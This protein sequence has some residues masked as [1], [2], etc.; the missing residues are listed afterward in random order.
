M[1]EPRVLLCAESL[2]AGRGGIARVARLTARVLAAEARSRGFAAEA[3]ALSDDAPVEDLGLPVRTARGSRLRFV[4]GVHRSALA[5]THLVYDFLGMARAHP[6]LPFLRLPSW[7]WINGIEVW[8]GAA[9]SRIA[10]GRRT[11][12]L[13]SISEHTR[14]RA[15]RFDEGFGRARICWLGTESD[16][17]PAPAPAA[18]RPPRAILVGRMEPGRDKGHEAVLSVWPRVVE[19]VPEA[20]LTIVGTGR[21]E[22]ELRRQAA[23]LPCARSVEFLGFVPEERMTAVLASADV[24][25]MPSRT[26]GFGLVYIEAM[27]HGVAVIASVH[28]AGA[29]VNLDG[30]TGFNVDLGR[31]AELLD[32]LVLLLRDRRKA[33]L[34]GENGRRRWAEH[35]RFGAFRARCA[36]LLDEFLRGGGGKGAP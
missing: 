6:R 23:G 30:V 36:A 3:L 17:P 32:R 1:A 7:S 2:R 26:E 10:A 31:S 27:R 35:F 14:A 33:R 22:G 4:C 18:D 24:L 5:C 12:F 29:E 9:R 25:A 15:S 20:V 21:A 34:L 19:A 8:E 13:V 28:D 11:S 16:E